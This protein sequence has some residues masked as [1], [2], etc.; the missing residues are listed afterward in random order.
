MVMMI[1]MMIAGKITMMISD[2]NDDYEND[3]TKITM[4]TIM[5]MGIMR[6]ITRIR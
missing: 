6:M 1:A 5:V 2:R 3:I 4:I